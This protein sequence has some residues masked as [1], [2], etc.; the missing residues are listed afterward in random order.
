M[1]A[2]QKRIDQRANR[3]E[4]SLEDEF[5]SKVKSFQRDSRS[6]RTSRKS[7]QELTSLIT[8]ALDEIQSEAFR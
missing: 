4:K 7:A 8:M 2:P 1:T 5:N 3:S 6:A